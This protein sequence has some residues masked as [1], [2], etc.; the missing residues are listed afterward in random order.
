MNCLKVFMKK[1]MTAFPDMR[2]VLP[3]D[4]ISAVC[5]NTAKNKS[6]MLADRL[7]GRPMEIATIVSLS[8]KKRRRPKNSSASYNV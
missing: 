6:S 3:L 4:A 2:S 8:L 5:R 1:L 7:A